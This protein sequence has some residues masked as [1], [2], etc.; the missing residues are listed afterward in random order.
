MK[1]KHKNIIVNLCLLILFS[2]GISCIGYSIFLWQKE[3]SKKKEEIKIQQIIQNKKIEED[4]IKQ[5]IIQNEKIEA[6]KVKADLDLKSLLIEKVKRKLENSDSVQF[7]E[8]ILI[9]NHQKKISIG[10]LFRT[11]LCGKVNIKD[12]Y[13]NYIGYKPFAIIIGGNSEIGGVSEEDLKDKYDVFVSA[14]EEDGNDKYESYLF[15]ANLLGCLSP[16]LA[17][18]SEA[19]QA[20]QISDMVNGWKVQKY[21]VPHNL[22]TT[23]KL[24]SWRSASASE[25]ARLSNTIIERAGRPDIGTSELNDCISNTAGDGG[26]D[27]L[28]VS[29]TAAVCILQK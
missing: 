27:N 25:R 4:I 17:A 23:D 2:F 19:Q 7:A 16:E 14:S 3:E 1:T 5:N 20:K 13:G 26:L 12:S 28:T 29:Q 15:T 24:D 6:E 22:S 21:Y 9:K 18:F 8:L 10:I 11:G